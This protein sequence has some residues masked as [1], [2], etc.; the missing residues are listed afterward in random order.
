[1]GRIA[2]A[3]SRRLTLGTNGSYR[4]ISRLGPLLLTAA[5]LLQHGTARAE[6]RLRLN[7]LAGR[8]SAEAAALKHFKQR[9]EAGTHGAIR[10]ELNLDGALGNASTSLENM[11]SGD[12]DLFS[13]NFE[14]YLPLVIDEVSGFELPFMIPS[15]DV[16]TRYIASPYMEEGR[17]RD[18]NLR[19]IRFLE[20][21][22]YRGPSRLIASTVPIKSLEALRGLRL[23]IIPTP[24]KPDIKVWQGLGVSIVEVKR[25]EIASAFERHAIDAIIVGSPDELMSANILKLAP[26]AGP[27]YDRPQVW[28]ISINEAAWQKLTPAQQDIVGKAAEEAANTYRGL[29]E[30]QFKALAAKLN[31]RFGRDIAIDALAAHRQLQPVYEHLIK[32]GGTAE[33]VRDAAN[34]AIGGS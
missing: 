30:K 31:G 24:S 12:L 21:D 23:A 29:Q 10:I 5:L 33:R 17:D 16:A 15:N 25:Q 27:I 3:G 34:Q 6:W 9:I 18:L 22:A 7:E 20:L 4:L 19:H 13:S 32:I 1:M 14:L 2:D 8:D 28:Q 11:S 26:Y